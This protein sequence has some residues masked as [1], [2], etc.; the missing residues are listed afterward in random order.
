MAARYSILADDLVTYVL[1]WRISSGGRVERLDHCAD[2]ELE[3]ALASAARVDS[4]TINRLLKNPLT[5]I[6]TI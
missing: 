6:E 2:P 5:A 1:G 4:A 3:V